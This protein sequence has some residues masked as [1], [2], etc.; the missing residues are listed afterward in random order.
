MKNSQG[1]KFN[2]KFR[3]NRDARENAVDTGMKKEKGPRAQANELKAKPESDTEEQ[4][5]EQVAPGVHDAV[6]GHLSK[7]K[8]IHIEHDYEN[9]KH[10]VAL[11]HTD[12][13]EAHSDHASAEEAYAHAGQAS[14]LYPMQHEPPEG[15][16]NPQAD[17]DDFE[18]TPLR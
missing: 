18:V 8:S 5:E 9:G 16:A 17:D 10:H 2:S 14:G 6:A 13:T 7:V 1:K 3:L 11:T 15:S 12:G 4:A